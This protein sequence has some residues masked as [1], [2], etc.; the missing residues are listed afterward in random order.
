MCGTHLGAKL[1]KATR[2]RHRCEGC[3]RVIP[4]GCMATYTVTADGRDMLGGY[5]CLDCEE[6][7]KTPTARRDYM[8]DDGCI[9]PDAFAEQP[10]ARFPILEPV[11]TT[12]KDKQ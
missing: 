5:W 7:I 4:K 11:T 12:P 3:G 10:Y 8:E 1:I 2:K 6:F 9:W